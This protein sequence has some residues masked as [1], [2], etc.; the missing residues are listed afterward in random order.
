MR[1][2]K[3]TQGVWAHAGLEPSVGSTGDSYAFQM[4][5]AAD[6]IIRGII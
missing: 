4:V 3:Y 6:Q 2:D 1:A 5:R